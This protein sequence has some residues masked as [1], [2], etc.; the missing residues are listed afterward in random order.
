[1]GTGV[2]YLYVVPYGATRTIWLEVRDP[3]DL[4]GVTA[5]QSILNTT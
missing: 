5:R 2:T 1:V 4:L 3:A